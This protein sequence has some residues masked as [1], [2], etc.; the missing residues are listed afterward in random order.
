VAPDKPSLIPVSVS[1]DFAAGRPYSGPHAVAINTVLRTRS[2]ADG[3]ENGPMGARRIRREQRQYDQ[4][5]SRRVN[6]VLK[7]DERQRRTRRMLE[8][9]QKGQ[10]PYTPAVQSWISTQLDKPARLVTPDE[11]KDLVKRLAE[12]K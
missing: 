6:G 5:L 12:K 4:A 1:H 10:F 2:S 9:I 11:V 8:L 7:T 3:R